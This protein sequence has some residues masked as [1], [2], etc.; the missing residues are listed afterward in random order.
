V[1]CKVLEFAILGALRVRHSPDASVLGLNQQSKLLLGRLLVEPG[2]RVTTDA[3]AEALWGED[4]RASRRNG[5]QVAIKAVRRSLADED[6]R[7]VVTDGDAYRIVV[8][9]PLRIDAERFKQL[10]NRGHRLVETNPRAAR[11]MLAEALSAW[12]GRLLEE[13][14]DKPWAAGY[15]TDLD[16][17]HDQAKVDLNE[18]RLVLGEHADLEREL[19]YQI[20]EHRFDER[21]RR[22]L[23]RALF[24]DGRA[25][26]ASSAYRDA[27]RELGAVGTELRRLGDQVARGTPDQPP[28]R[29][30]SAA[31]AAI[32]DRGHGSV[33]LCAG[34]VHRSPEEPGLGT[35]ALLID[36]HRGVPRP[37]DPD[38]LIATFQDPEAALRAARAIASDSRLSA[39]IGIHV[40]A[41]FAQGDRLLGPGPARCW[42]LADAAHPGQVLVS[43]AA[44]S[45]AGADDDLY[46]L[47]VQGLADLGPPEM[48]FELQ[49]PGGRTFPLAATLNEWRNN[50]P[51][52]PKR[53]IGR[54]EELAI[55]SR[56]V[57]GGSLIT[58]T[59]AGGCGKTR[60]A[61]QVT[62]KRMRAFADGAWFVDLAGI[63]PGAGIEAV[64]GAMA[65]QLGVRSLPHETM[66]VAVVRHL[67][68]RSAIVILDNCEQVHE[69][70]AELV[71]SI[72]IGSPRVCIVATSRCRLSIDGETVFSVQPMETAIGV[73]SDAVELLLDRA[74]PLPST[75]A[76]PTEMLTHAAFITRAL[77]G[78]PLAI[79]LAAGQVATRG[80]AGVAAEV[81]AMIGSGRPLG[82]ASRDAVQPKRHRTLESAIEWSYRLL[83]ERERLALRQLAVFRGTFGGQEAQRL[84]HAIAD[85]SGCLTDLL[86]CS[87]LAVAPAVGRLPRFRL[88]TPIRAFAI[89]LLDQEGNLDP[90]REHH[91]E[92]FLALAT[93]TAPDLFGAGEQAALE[94][95]EADHD[96]LRGALDWYVER[97]R[98]EPAL[99]L[100]GALWWLW[101]SHGHLEE[102]CSWVR[103]SLAIDDFPTPARTQALRT[104]SHL[105]WWRGDLAECQSFGM[106]LAACADAIEDDWGR[107]W[108][109]MAYGSVELFAHPSTSLRL[110]EES[111]RRFDALDRSW[112]AG[113]AM[114]IIAAARWFG[115][116][117]CGALEVFE[118]ATEIFE[119]LGHRSMLA[120]AQRGAGLMAARR[121]NPARGAAMCSSARRISDAV[122]HRAGSAEALNFLAA[123]KRD[124]GDYE[125]AV[126]R[127]AEALLLARE[128]N[129]LWATCWALDG[130]A[131]AARTLD[132]PE[133]AARLYAHSGRVEERAGYRP[134]PHERAI[135]DHDIDE[136]RVELGDDNFEGAMAEGALMDTN[137]AVSSALAVA[138]RHS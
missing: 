48:L 58:L 94:R 28:A 90:M 101:F 7:V 19:R 66:A 27:V 110:L 6:R 120:A 65:A 21:L 103:L 47:G 80:L 67:S 4:D 85:V 107:A 71:R 108:V 40:G 29:L 133:I 77:D 127:Y 39:K 105:A 55:L 37:I 50:L 73:P 23:I 53:F 122:G 81:A 44:R 104:G 114:Q 36:R 18:V 121:G 113:Y 68:D 89:R 74:G 134:P 17:A 34:L 130:L 1:P 51:V 11:P 128:A 56:I 22:Q 95:L 87:M 49:N 14:A 26:E 15:A 131:G 16:R 75:E 98:S 60:L 70:C 5:V 91:A 135:R 3:L 63:E 112:E 106:A 102:G 109:P 83:S 59:G 31:A 88:L 12:R 111:K 86:E 13:F 2:V 125:S 46:D 93:R 42:Q 45:S 24:A 97:G 123:I 115:G 38:R 10:A 96:N 30:A 57:A 52:Q 76:D 78:I 8:E 138:S 129:D 9:N 100:V 62:A 79:E 43:A 124:Q 33:V 20:D 126:V 61:L 69:A 84:L 137:E 35:V 92:V 25:A 82:F 72:L 64:S 118:E 32:H 117:E 136:L 99:R 41:V 116:D 132:Q 119:Q 54:A